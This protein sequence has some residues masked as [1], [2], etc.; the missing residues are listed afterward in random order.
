[1]GICECNMMDIL[2][3]VGV[4]EET[5]T[6]IKLSC[7]Q[8]DSIIDESMGKLTSNGRKE[9]RVGEKKSLSPREG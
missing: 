8:R 7:R 3:H 2:T 9:K 5:F 1:M 6:R 4:Y